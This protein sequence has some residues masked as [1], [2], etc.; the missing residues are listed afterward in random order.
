MN[1]R[2]QN[3]VITAVE[4]AAIETPVMEIPSSSIW[5]GRIMKWIILV[6]AFLTPLFY[7]SYTSDVLFAKVVLVE[8]AAII[9]GAAW[10]LNVLV[11]KQVSYKRTPLNAAFLAS[12]L[13][14]I[15]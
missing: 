4:E 15:A 11:T 6:T 1:E 10:L 13:A 12:A 14:L 7:L 8:I 9:A 3:E 5:L 2:N